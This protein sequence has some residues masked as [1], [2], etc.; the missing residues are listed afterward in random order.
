V[1][2]KILDGISRVDEDL[3][4][5]YIDFAVYLANRQQD[6]LFGR[7][8]RH[9]LSFF[10]N[11]DM[12]LNNEAAELL[13]LHDGVPLFPCAASSSATATRLLPPAKRVLR[14]DPDFEFVGKPF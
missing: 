11:S 12:D 7:I 8:D 13:E 4:R 1:L 10:G 9:S 5:V 2:N 6:V 14:N 3:M